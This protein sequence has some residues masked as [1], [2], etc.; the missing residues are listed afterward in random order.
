MKLILCLLALI[1]LNVEANQ[2]LFKLKN[3]DVA[4]IPLDKIKTGPLTYNRTVLPSSVVKTFNVFRGYEREYQGYDL[5]TLLDAIY[6][7]S[8]RSQKRITF[9]AADGN[10]QISLI[11]DMLKAAKGMKGHLAYA[12]NGKTSFT[13]VE[14][15]G[16]KIDPAPL[17]LVWSNFSAKD[18]ASPADP[19]K[20]PYQLAVITID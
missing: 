4:S 8:W 17:C 1:S 14:K 13:F 19:L 7:T 11:A 2:L 12:E 9:T 6:G 15:D 18:K 10:S 5:F 20:W 16:H 3:K